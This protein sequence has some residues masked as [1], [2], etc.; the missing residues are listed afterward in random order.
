MEPYPSLGLKEGLDASWTRHDQVSW[1]LT[2]SS[3]Y[4]NTSDLHT[5]CWRTAYG[6]CGC[7]Y[8]NCVGL[9]P[10]EIYKQTFPENSEMTRWLLMIYKYSWLIFLIMTA[11]ILTKVPWTCNFFRVLQ[12][13]KAWSSLYQFNDILEVCL[14][15]NPILPLFL[16]LL[17]DPMATLCAFFSLPHVSLVC[18]LIRMALCSRAEWQSESS[19]RPGTSKGTGQVSSS[20]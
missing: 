12:N 2:R 7:E 20:A 4:W 16:C 8:L 18:R 14:Q 6:H 3:L 9:A 11:N 13:L 19:F 10:L 15:Y 5:R 1:R 17:L